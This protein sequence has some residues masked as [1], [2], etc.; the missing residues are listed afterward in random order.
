MLE[1]AT[2]PAFPS[3]DLCKTRTACKNGRGTAIPNRSHWAVSSGYSDL[4]LLKKGLHRSDT[5]L[6][7]K[8]QIHRRPSLATRFSIVVGFPVNILRNGS[9]ILN[10]AAAEQIL[11]KKTIDR[12]R[13]FG[14]CAFESVSALRYLS[15]SVLYGGARF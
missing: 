15:A 13:L 3:A 2:R 7:A 5:E 6:R 4:V 1:Y 14:S 11:R 8:W 9:A 10:T 12:L